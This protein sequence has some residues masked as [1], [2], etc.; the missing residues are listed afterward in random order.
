MFEDVTTID[1]EIEFKRFYSKLDK[2]IKTFFDEIKNVTSIPF[3]FRFKVTKANKNVYWF[4]KN[5]SLSAII[6]E[7]N[8]I[9]WAYLENYEFVI[10]QCDDMVTNE[11]ISY[12][13]MFNVIDIV[14][15]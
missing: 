2:N 9:T 3:P 12:I 10:M 1:N 6:D 4:C 14:E 11:L 15:A 8:M 5:H 7:R 13:S